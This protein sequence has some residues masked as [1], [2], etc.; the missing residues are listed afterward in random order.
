[1]LLKKLI[2]NLPKNLQAIKINGLSL[3]SRKVKK[4]D[5]F[6]AL[7]GSKENGEKFIN[8]AIKNGAA[9]IVYSSNKKFNNTKNITVRVKDIK[10][11]LS[12]SCR[13]FYGLKPKNIIAVTGTNGKSSVADFFHQILFLNKLPVASIGTLGIKKN[14][15]I[16]KFNLT[17]PD[18]ISA[19][20]EL[21]KLKKAN[22][23]NV[24]I[25]A[26]SHGLQQGRLNG[27]NFKAGIF[28][29]FSQD[30]LDYHKSMKK[31]FNAKMI[32]FSQLL[33]ENNY[34]ITDKKLKEF[35]IIKK[36]AK[37]NKLNIKDISNVDLRKETKKTNLIGSFQLKNL[38]MSVAAAQ[39]C[40]ISKKK[41]Y[42]VLDKIRNVDGRLQFI[43]ELSNKSK[44]YIDYAHTP[45]A[46]L[47]TLNSLKYYYKKNISLVFGCGGERDFKKRSLMANIAKSFCDKIYVTDDNPRNESPKKIRKE[48]IK[49]LKG[50]NY[51]EIGNRKE[52]II[53][54]IRN[55]D[56]F[57]II[58]VAG[59]GHEKFQDYGNKI[60]NISDKEIIKKSKIDKSQ[61]NKQK[62]ILN[63]NKKIIKKILTNKKDYKFRGISTN[64]KDIKKNNLF[65]AIKGKNNDGHKFISEAIR[66]GAK[67]CAVSKL[68][69]KN[70]NLIKVN[71][72]EIFLKKIALIKRKMTN[73]TIIAVTGSAGK[74]TVKDLL[75]NLLG[76]YSDTYFSPKSFNN[77]YGVPIS[78]ANIE[79]N[80]RYGVFEVGM[81]NPGEINKLSRL[82]KPN[83]AIITNIAE[84]HI[85]NF[86]NIEGIAK[87]KSEI[88]NNIEK[89]GTLILNQDDFFYSFLSNLAKKRNIKV[90]SFGLNNNANV[91][92]VN[93]KKTKHFYI[94]KIKIYKE[95]VNLQFNNVN[96][97][98][99]LASLAALKELNL[100]IT[101]IIQQ[102]KFFKM[103]RGRGRIY[104]IERYRTN[105]NLI[106]ESYN[107][108][109]LSVKN[110]I[111]N[112]S[113]IKDKNSKKY[114]LLSDM[115]E[116]GDKS[117]FY[118]KNL[119]KIINKTDIDKVFVYGDKIL[120]TYKYIKKKKQGNIL[121]HESDF[122][123]I[124]SNL[125][126]KNDYLM[127]KGSNAT[128]LHNFSNK[129]IKGRT[130]AI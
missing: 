2:N 98:S 52:A 58:L 100:D 120:N 16:K 73:A 45:D 107:A 114:V 41:I 81:S 46:L 119:S 118:H 34:I 37:K 7:K 27:I 116:L 22:I 65:I 104:K 4:G 101:K 128:G 33:K 83:I 11:T 51:L 105:F 85:E 115:L 87:A 14:N 78:L 23:D 88:I 6:F 3:D 15:V 36:V 64:S 86:K 99:L 89:N 97:Y 66:N 54:A 44:I 55:A 63:W 20:K 9:A 72:T 68:D 49:N 110:A 42:Q 77:R 91:Y 35:G 26:S 17:S 113:K 61:I 50:T 28:T 62:S 82:I 106:D 18:I 56:P 32:L 67:F 59:K 39:I 103:P 21:A 90:I 12:R 92:P 109:P 24:I 8:S 57:E 96:I 19:H 121:Q 69:N 102:I 125:I 29:N 111:L 10:S 13:Y 40:G 117:E 25:E 70:K 129:I 95:I 75:G 31:Y 30:H 38:A 48:I 112:L 108:N 122:D 94:A 130:H 127:I 5:L 123:E 76:K 53:T 60:I 80:H 93:I 74:T 84:A 47:T 126:K 124:F 1:M 71:N 79:A 43:K